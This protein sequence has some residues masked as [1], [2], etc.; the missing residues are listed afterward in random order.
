MNTA[1]WDRL[2]TVCLFVAAPLPA[3]LAESLYRVAP[4]DPAA[5]YLTPNR[6]DVHADGVHDDTQG[7]QAAI[8]RA[9]S[10]RSGGLVFV[11]SGYCFTI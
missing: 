8:D 4:E 6:F 2:A 11:P 10:D 1:L 7:I 3:S 9:V 5:V